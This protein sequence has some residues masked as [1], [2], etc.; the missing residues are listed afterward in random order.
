VSGPGRRRSLALALPALGLGLGMLVACA[1]LVGIVDT[2]GTRSQDAGTSDGS[3][4]PVTGEGGDDVAVP[5][6]GEA[7]P[8]GTLPPDAN[9][10]G[11]AGPA[12]ADGAADTG[13]ASSPDAA[14]SPSATRCGAT[15][16]EVCT[17]G[18][19]ASSA[20]PVT[21]P[22][23]AAGQCALQGPPLVQVSGFTIDGTEVTVAQYQQFLNAKGSDT[24]GQ[25]S[26]CAWNK[27]YDSAA[28]L[29]PATWPITNI[30]W[31]DA[32]AYCAWAGEHLCGKIGGGPLAGADVLVETKS[33]WFLACGGPGGSSHPNSSS[34]C[35]SSG[36]TGDLAPVGSTAGCQGFYPGIF[37]M[38]GNA[39]EWVDSCDST[40]AGATDTCHLLGGS[41]IDNQSYCTESF[42]YPRNETAYPFGFRC[43]GG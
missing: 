16:R 30:D 6:S 12:P 2:D 24:S 10:G 3:P 5:P 19:W 23:C 4:A 34:K 32:F 22:A 17:A 29:N 9:P 25:P 15:G 21:Q 8:D 38:E 18:Q 35:N 14:C 27:S 13:N 28:A 11:D 33:Q 36:G 20:C 7:G 43:C 39:A 26:V 1:K 42:D 41:Y 31:C 40:D 37:D